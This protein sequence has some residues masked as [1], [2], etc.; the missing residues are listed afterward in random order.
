MAPWVKCEHEFLGLGP[1][2]PLVVCVCNPTMKQEVE[3]SRSVE[4]QL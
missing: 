3:I 4:D 2:P 1:Q